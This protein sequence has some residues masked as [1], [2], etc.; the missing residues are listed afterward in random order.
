MAAVWPVALPDR[1]L[2]DGYREA[3]PD[4]AIRTQMDAGPP[5]VRRRYTAGFR[6]TQGRI[7]CTAAQVATL[8]TFYVT[9]CAGGSLPFDWVNSRT[10]GTVS[11]QWRSSPLLEPNHKDS[12]FVT[13][14]VLQL[15]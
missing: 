6:P 12:Y 1:F 11:F 8:E 5:K 15:P 13:L 9:T 3:L 14:D 4:T 10:G 2:V 7:E